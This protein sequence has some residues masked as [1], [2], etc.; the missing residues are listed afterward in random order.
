MVDKVEQEMEKIAPEAAKRLKEWLDEERNDCYSEK[1][2]LVFIELSEIMFQ[3][4]KST[5]GK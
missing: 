3:H 1:S 2:K 4:G 5:Q